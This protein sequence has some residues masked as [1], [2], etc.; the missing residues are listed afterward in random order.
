MFELGRC[1]IDTKR[2]IAVD[3]CGVIPELYTYGTIYIL[4]RWDND[5]YYMEDESNLIEYDKYW[6]DKVEEVE[7]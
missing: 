2:R 5:E 1:A 7:E 6:F 4:K 3:V